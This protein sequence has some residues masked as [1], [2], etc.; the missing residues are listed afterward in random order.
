LAPVSG[1]VVQPALQ[2]GVGAGGQGA[3]LV[4]GVAVFGP[5]RDAGGSERGVQGQAALVTGGDVDA[6]AFGGVGRRQQ[7]V[8]V[9]ASGGGQALSAGSA[10]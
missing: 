1:G 2:G 9:L 8:G 5:G 10:A 7:A 3:E 6:E 4:D